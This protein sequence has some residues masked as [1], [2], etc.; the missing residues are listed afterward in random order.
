MK[1]TIG[2]GVIFQ[3]G[4][5]P[6]LVWCNIKHPVAC[7][8]VL[9]AKRMNSMLVMTLTTLLGSSIPTINGEYDK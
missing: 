1:T 2:K 3:Q 6:L 7:V 9:K 4:K 5:S 8:A